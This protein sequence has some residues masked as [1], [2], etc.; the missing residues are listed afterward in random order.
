MEGASYSRGN[1]RARC[2]LTPPGCR[3]GAYMHT[4]RIIN[5]SVHGV[6]VMG[7]HRGHKTLRM[8]SLAS[9]RTRFPQPWT[10]G[11]APTSKPTRNATKIPA[12]SGQEGA[13]RVAVWE[14]A[15][16]VDDV[17]VLL[18]KACRPRIEVGK[19]SHGGFLAFHIKQRSAYSGAA[20]ASL[21]R[22]PATWRIP[23]P[24]PSARV[25]QRVR[26]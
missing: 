6:T 10:P 11:P 8:T 17:L 26:I 2:P 1:S 3:D 19:Q 7:E 23:K 15:K 12:A 24:L 16:P 4:C 14:A 25:R 20:K 9:S 5:T 13:H 18:C 22:R 21:E